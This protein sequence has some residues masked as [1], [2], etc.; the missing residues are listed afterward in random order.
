MSEWNP[1]EVMSKEFAMKAIDEIR[2]FYRRVYFFPEEK[3]F[4]G[5][6]DFEG[7]LQVLNGLKEMLETRIME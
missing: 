2:C 1:G 4:N 3:P 6:E 5:Q 7:A